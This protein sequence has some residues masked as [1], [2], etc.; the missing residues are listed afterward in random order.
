MAVCSSDC[1]VETLGGSCL[2]WLSMRCWVQLSAQGSSSSSTEAQELTRYCTAGA[3][4]AAACCSLIRPAS[5]SASVWA[6]RAPKSAQ[7]CGGSG[8]GAA[9]M[10]R[11]EEFT[12]KRGVF[13]AYKRLPIGTRSPVVG[14]SWQLTTGPIS[15]LRVQNCQHSTKDAPAGSHRLPC[16]GLRPAAAAWVLCW[17]QPARRPAP[18]GA[19]QQRCFATVSSSS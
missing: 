10:S 17:V 1:G 16:S 8:A 7:S 14:C 12:P 11:A 13:T 5:S 15:A 19:Q 6:A 2:G 4:R 18:C 9:A 3:S